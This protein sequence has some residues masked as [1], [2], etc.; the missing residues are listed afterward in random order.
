[1]A[2]KKKRRRR[3]K[4]GL[5][6]PIN[7][8]EGAAAFGAGFV[9][10]PDPT[11]G[12]TVAQ[13]Q[14]QMLKLPALGNKTISAGLAIYYGNKFLLKNKWVGMFG[15]ALTLGGVFEFGRRKGTTVQTLTGDDDESVVGWDTAGAYDADDFDEEFEVEG[16]IGDHERLED[17]DD[18]DDESAGDDEHDPLDD[19]PEDR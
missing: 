2:R 18:D 3:S 10:Q 5:G 13:I 1:M 6:L 9:V 12:G 14:T 7:A 16:T 17:D 4:R 11:A 8:M 15:K 19:D